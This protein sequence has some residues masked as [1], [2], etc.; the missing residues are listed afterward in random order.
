MT[1]LR[2]LIID[3]EPLARARVRAFLN[4]HSSV[5]VVGEY[6]DGIAALVAIRGER[7]DLVFLDVQMPGCDGFQLLAELPADERP[8]IILVTAHDHFALDGFAVQAIDYLLKPFSKERFDLAL[9]R[10]VQHICTKRAGDLGARIEGMLAAGPESQPGRVAVKSDG[11]L[12]FLKPDDIIWI[13]AANNYATLH[14]A[15]AKRLL[16][17]ETLSS[18]EKRLAS[19]RFVRVNRSALVHVDQVQE[20]QPV[21]YG[22][23]SV[24]LRNGTRI[25][26]SRSLRGRFEKTVT[27][28]P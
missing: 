20:L 3:D 28:I 6:G 18:L 16:L 2:A 13:E 23:F 12:I 1:M 10:A 22:D 9:K 26:L 7:P 19:S 11:R 4:D 21:E 24:L 14:L 25:P 27:G 5:E 8:A 17:R 15:G